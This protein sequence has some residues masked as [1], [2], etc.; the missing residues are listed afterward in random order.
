MLNGIEMNL[1]EMCKEK[2]S[3]QVYP[4]TSHIDP[5]PF[6]SQPSPCQEKL[7]SHRML[8]SPLRKYVIEEIK[9]PLRKALIAG[10]SFPHLVMTFITIIVTA[11]KIRKY[12]GKVTRE[13]SVFRNVH[14]LLDLAQLVKGCHHNPGREA[15]V[16]SATEIAIAVIE[17]DPY[18]RH[19][20]YSMANYIINQ[21]EA[22]RWVTLSEPPPALK[23]YWD[24]NKF[25]GGITCQ[26]Q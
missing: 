11:W 19:I 10:K 17:H 16:N 24:E 23:S 4:P 6:W 9:D 8:A 25:Q 1:S 12:V 21:A 5:I 15:M 22:G 18:Y 2:M 26:K 3:Y 13:N 20:A 14:V 7:F